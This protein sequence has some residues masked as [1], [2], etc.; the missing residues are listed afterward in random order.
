MVVVCAECNGVYVAQTHRSRAVKANLVA[1]TLLYSRRHIVRGTRSAVQYCT[2]LLAE[3]QKCRNAGP[4]V[5][6]GQESEKTIY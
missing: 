4:T 6:L 1:F 3:M 5:K 2:R